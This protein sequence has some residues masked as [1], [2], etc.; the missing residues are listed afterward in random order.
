MDI[1]GIGIMGGI[2]YNNIVPG[3][4]SCEGGRSESV[5]SLLLQY[6]ILRNW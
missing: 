5:I 2:L 6:E 3:L 1:S 4:T